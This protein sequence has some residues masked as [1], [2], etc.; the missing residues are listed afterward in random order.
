MQCFGSKS[1]RSGAIASDGAGVKAMIAHLFLT[2][3]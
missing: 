3:Q 1:V 2:W